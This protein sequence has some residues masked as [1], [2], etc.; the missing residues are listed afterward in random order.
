MDGHASLLTWLNTQG[1]WLV[2]TLMM[3]FA[4]STVVAWRKKAKGVALLM[5]HVSSGVLAA[6]LFIVGTVFK[7]DPLLIIVVAGP[8]S[9]G[10]SYAAFSLLLRLSDRIEVRGD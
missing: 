1:D 3:S 10:C 2:A 5:S 8:V 9:G 4:T 6:I 7:Y